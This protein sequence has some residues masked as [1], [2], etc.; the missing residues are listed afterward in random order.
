M[1]ASNFHPT[2]SGAAVSASTSKPVSELIISQLPPLDDQV[3]IVER[4]GLGHPDTICD[5]LAEAL[6]RALCSE[7]RSKFGAIL[8][9][10][11]DKAL[12]CA[13]RAAPAFGG[14]AVLA[15]IQVYLAGR[16]AHATKGGRID[17]A[18]IA[19]ETATAWLN[20]NM[21][22]L[23]AE[24]DVELHPQIQPGSPDLQSLFS[25][26]TN[27][28]LAN[29]T[30]I[31]AGYAPLSPLERLVLSIERRINESERSAHPAWG[32]DVKVT[33]IRRGENVDVTIACA[34]I[35]RHLPH[36]DYYL[37][38]KAAIAALAQALAAEHGFSN[39]ACA[40][41]PTILSRARSIS[42]SPAP[43]P[44]PAT[45]ARS[46]AATE[47]TGLLLPAGR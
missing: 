16:A 30:S 47:S 32:E 43:R 1:G 6:S 40:I 21:H 3:E 19:V 35:G 23:D 11:V 37:A 29:D 31:G 39:C 8:H 25:R 9:H 38:E 33:G 12:L 14:G 41:S 42:P 15:P 24:R 27:V 7:Y 45:T 26:G 2:T 10:N 13:G 17:V 44:R 34:M 4:K 46:D 22:A 20:A 36:I 18:G 28:P 5:A